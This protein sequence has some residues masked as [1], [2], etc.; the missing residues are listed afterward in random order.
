[1]AFWSQ[2]DLNLVFSSVLQ[3]YLHNSTSLHGRKKLMQWRYS[4]WYFWHGTLCVVTAQLMVVIIYFL[5]RFEPT[6]FL[7]QNKNEEITNSFFFFEGEW[8]QLSVFAQ[9]LFHHIC[10]IRK[11]YLCPWAYFNVNTIAFSLWLQLDV[12]GKF[13]MQA[14]L[15][16]ILQKCH[17]ERVNLWGYI[18]SDRKSVV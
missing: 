17:L 12:P 18:K 6:L 1:M 14:Y 10:L 4:M 9:N 11:E 15:I 16:F 3:G 5:C 13:W 7:S 8:S 2:V